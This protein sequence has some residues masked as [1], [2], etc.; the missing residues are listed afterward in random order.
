MTDEEGWFKNVFVTGPGFQMAQIFVESVFETHVDWTKII[1]TDDNYKNILQVKIQKEFK[2]TPDYLEIS[3]H[4]DQGYEMG[5][6]LCLG[7]PIHQMKLEASVPFSK[8]GSFQK[9]QEELAQKG[10]VFVFL[11]SGIHKIK[12]KAEQIASELSIRSFL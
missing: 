12:K 7:K 10:S 11:G 3:H 5:V 4:L 8:Y 2:T 6:Y 1:N 9:I